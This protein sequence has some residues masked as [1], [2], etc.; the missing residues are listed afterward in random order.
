MGLVVDTNNRQLD[1]HQ[2]D[3][4]KKN[5]ELVSNRL[6]ITEQTAEARILAEM[7]R[8][9]DHNTAVATGTMS[10]GS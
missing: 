6:G 2:Y 7:L 3:F 10:D 5:A 4:A 9:S 1:Q 8:N